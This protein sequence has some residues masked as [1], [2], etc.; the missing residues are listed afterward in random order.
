MDYL[1]TF[2]EGIA[3]FIS[4]CLLPMLPI[5][6]SYFVGEDDSNTR[7]AF[8]NSIGFVIGFTF[9]FLV[10]SIFASSIGNL[11]VNYIKYIKIIFGILIILLGLNYME[12]L[13]IKFLNKT[14][15]RKIE[16]KNLNFWKAIIFGLLFSIS[17]TPCIGT[18][19]SSAL[20]LVAKEQDMLKGIMM[21]LIYS[22]GLGIPFVVSAILIEKL[23]NV[24]QYI[25]SHYSIIKKISGIILIIAGIYTIIF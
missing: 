3:S 25:K 5:Y 9:I 6:I 8:I 7:K 17:W 14:N 23:K 10:L 1:L 22:I 11:I 4:P 16:Y 24:F 20:L 15:M 12:I 18:F 13:K 19:L 2:L 21:M